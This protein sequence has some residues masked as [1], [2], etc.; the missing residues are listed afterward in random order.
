MFRKSFYDKTHFLFPERNLSMSGFI[1]SSIPMSTCL[2]GNSCFR[3]S[4]LYNT[5]ITT[6]PDF[7]FVT[8]Q[9]KTMEC[10]D[11]GK[12]YGSKDVLRT[13]ILRSHAKKLLAITTCFECAKTFH[14]KQALARHHLLT[15]GSLKSD[16][17]I[18]ER[19][20]KMKHTPAFQKFR[21]VANHI[22]NRF[23]VPMFD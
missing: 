7:H 21:Q 18:E 17:R 9:N 11:C 8:E 12:C 20:K 13:H 2:I 19:K 1:L 22:V 23:T 14:A 5:M 4:L 15:Q 10:F 3:R 16:H 6:I